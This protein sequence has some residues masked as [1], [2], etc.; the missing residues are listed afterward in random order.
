MGNKREGHKVLE[1]ERERER[2]K[3][4]KGSGRTC[5]W[6]F[7]ASFIWMSDAVGLG[8]GSF[9]CL[10]TQVRV[11]REARQVGQID[12]AHPDPLLQAEGV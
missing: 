10:Q 4:G 11:G 6:E 9:V 12:W 2:E 7:F 5:T 3:D 8:A 1:R